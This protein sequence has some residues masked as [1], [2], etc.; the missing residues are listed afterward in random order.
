MMKPQIY[1]LLFPVL[2]SLVLIFSKVSGQVVPAFP[3]DPD[4]GDQ[5][6]PDIAVDNEGNFTVV[7]AGN[8]T[9]Y[10]ATFDSLGHTRQ[11]P[12]P[13]YGGSLVDS[14]AHP[15]IAKQAQ[16]SVIVWRHYVSDPGSEPNL[17]GLL[18]NS[19]SNEVSRDIFDPWG[20]YGDRFPDVAYINDSTFSLTWNRSSSH[21]STE[22]GVHSQLLTNSLRAVGDVQKVNDDTLRDLNNV[23]PHIAAKPEAGQAVIFWQD[24][25]TGQRQVYGRR[26]DSQGLPQDTSFLVSDIQNHLDVKYL[27]ADIDTMGRFL[28]TW[29]GQVDSIFSIFLRQYAFDGTPLGQILKVNDSEDLESLHSVVDISIDADGSFVVVWDELK[30]GFWTTL[31]QRFDSDGLKIGSNF[32]I[33]R[34]DTF[35]QGYPRVKL[36][37]RT[38]YTVW[39]NW[40]PPNEDKKGQVWVKLLG[41]D[42][43]LFIQEGGRQFPAKVYL[44]QNHP[45][46]FNRITVL[47]FDLERT[48]DVVT[49]S[50]YNILGQLV[51]RFPLENLRPGKHTVLWDGRDNLDQPLPSGVYVYRLSVDAK[52]L[53]RKMLLIK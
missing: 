39:R 45:N 29:A 9:I 16:Y 2:V 51:K 28:V 13:I 53:T 11:K 38:I 43:P 41:F 17:S 47:S 42:D 21:A 46:P 5:Y 52:T 24:D 7:W 23:S 27:A 15:K 36:R 26:T 49:L 19:E 50:I 34:P 40:W 31:A 37:N 14:R 30:N 18:L 1:R 6:E 48:S 33:T 44:H 32:Y 12:A 8:N 22:P 10:L 25:R 35:H 20:E 4:T 3:V